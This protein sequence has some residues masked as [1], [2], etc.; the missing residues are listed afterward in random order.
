[1]GRLQLLYGIERQK[2]NSLYLNIIYDFLLWATLIAFGVLNMVEMLWD[3]RLCDGYG[4][5]YM[6]RRCDIEM[7]RLLVVEMVV[8]NLGLLVA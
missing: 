8:V 4:D 5:D 6:Y 2:S 3:R 1:L 7:F